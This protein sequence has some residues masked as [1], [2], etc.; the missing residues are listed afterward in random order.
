MSSFKIPG[1]E[2]ILA[3]THHEDPEWHALRRTGVGASEAAPLMAAAAQAA[4]AAPAPSA[5]PAGEGAESSPFQAI[6]MDAQAGLGEVATIAQTAADEG[7]IRPEDVARLIA[8][9]NNPSDES[10]IGK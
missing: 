8:F 1:A 6:A 5:A 3:P 9:R 7:Y 4:P 2:E 10:W